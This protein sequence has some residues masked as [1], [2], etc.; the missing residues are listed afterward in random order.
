MSDASDGGE[1]TLE[2]KVVDVDDPQTVSS[3]EAGTNS[4][5]RPKLRD[6]D[7]ASTH[8]VLG[9]LH[10][11][12]KSAHLSEGTKSVSQGGVITVSMD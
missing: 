4:T 10:N 11:L 8:M 9:V 6:A 2:D 7:R 1:R 12:W 3:D 5:L